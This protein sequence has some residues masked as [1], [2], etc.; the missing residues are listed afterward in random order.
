MA[1]LLMAV[2]WMARK[3]K[4]FLDRWDDKT[5]HQQVRTLHRNL[6]VIICELSHLFTHT[7]LCGRET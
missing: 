7:N 2:L 6:C 5:G 1:V 3:A 4:T